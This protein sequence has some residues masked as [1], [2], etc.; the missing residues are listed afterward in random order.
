MDN[1]ES[2]GGA[3]AITPTPP[4]TTPRDPVGSVAARLGGE[5][6]QK[7]VGAGIVQ[8]ETP[9]PIDLSKMSLEQLQTLKSV[10][11]ATPDAPTRVKKNKMT[12]TL[13]RIDG[14]MVADFKNAYLGLVK[15]AENRREVERHLIPIKFFGETEY[16]SILYSAFINSERVECEVLKTRSETEETVEGTTISRQ[17]G[18]PVQ[19]VATKVISWFVVRLPNGEEVEIEGHIANG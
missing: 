19:M 18:L 5:E 12:V 15:D 2:T 4:T 9:L 6:G 10:L 14:Q 7:D 16:H 3:G 1:N 13:R 8:P 11:A 17:T